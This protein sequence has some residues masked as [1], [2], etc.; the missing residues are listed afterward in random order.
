MA[1]IANIVV[2][3]SGAVAHTFN[4]V[5]TSREGDTQVA[6]WRENAA[7]VP[8]EAQSTIIARLQKSKSGVNRV[9]LEVVVPTLE[10]IGAQNAAGYTAAPKVAYVLRGKAQFF[11]H[12]RTTEAN[13]TFVRQILANFVN[14]VATNVAPTTTGLVPD[15]ADRVLF[16]T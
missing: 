13:R 4:P 12:P 11:W 10:T 15:L 6:E 2:Y 1:N 16:P 8:L 7:G 14:G 3:D 9:D 5:S